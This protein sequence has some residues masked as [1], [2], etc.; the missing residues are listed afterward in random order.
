M[1]SRKTIFV[2]TLLFLTAGCIFAGLL[3]ARKELQTA[4]IET[5]ILVYG[6]SLGGTS[7]AIIAAEQE[8]N[9]VFA[10][11]TNIM[12]GQA[13]ES[14]LSAFD[15]QRRQWETWG[16]YDDLQQYL[17]KKMGKN[18]KSK[19]AGLGISVVG[20]V[21]SP[22]DEI[23]AFFQER[24][25]SNQRITLFT[26]HTISNFKKKKGQWYQATL[27]N[28]QNNR[29]TR[30]RFQYLVDGTETG[31][32]FEQ[33]GTPFNI[34]LDA[35][36]ETGEK[37]ALPKEV[38]DAIVNGTTLNGKTL[39][40]LGNRVQAVASPFILLD[41]GY[42][43]DF[44]PFSA[45]TNPCLSPDTT[46]K[47]M[48][49]DAKVYRMEQEHCTARIMLA[50]EFTDT[51]DVYLVSHG[52]GFVQSA[53]ASSL[54]PNNPLVRQLHVQKNKETIHVGAFP[55]SPE[56]QT[57]L[58]VSHSA[59]NPLV[60]G[61]LLVKKNM[62]TAPVVLQ[63][64]KA[65]TIPLVHYD[66]PSVYA[67][68]YLTGT[69]LPMDSAPSI[70]NKPTSLEA[71][72][73]TLYIPHI[74]LRDRPSLELPSGL[75]D[76]L[77]SIVIIPT[78][79]DVRPLQFFS[80]NP[81]KEIPVEKIP[82]ESTIKNTDQ[83]VREWQFTAQDDGMTVFA[84]DSPAYQWRLLELWQDEPKQ[85]V[86]SLIFSLQ[87]VS[88]NPSPLFTAKL[89]KGSTY[90]LRIG[91]S[92]GEKW[93]SFTISADAIN[94]SVSLYTDSPLKAI[95]PHQEQQEGIYDLWAEGALSSSVSCTLERP[96][97][98]NNTLQKTITHPQLE[99]LGKVF[100]DRS[101]TLKINENG[102]TVIAIPNTAV[103]T[104]QWSGTL[105]GESPKLT[106]TTLPPGIFNVT[107]TGGP[108]E[109][110]Q[111]YALLEG[112][113][114][115]VQT[116]SIP[117]VKTVI[118]HRLATE[119]FVSN[120]RPLTLT[121]APSFSQS[122]ITLHFYKKIPNLQDALTFSMISHPLTP[123]SDRSRISL[124]F[125][126]NIVS[127]ES[128]LAGKP[129]GLLPTH[130]ARKTLGM[131]V[132][133]DGPN[134]YAGF[135]AE[136]IDSSAV[137]AASRERSEAFAYWL[138][139]DSALTKQNLNCD[140]ADVVCTPKR[141]QPVIGLFQDHLSMFPPK[142]Y[143]REGR[144]MVAKRMITLNDVGI[145]IQ[146]C[147]PTGCPAH[148]L[149]LNAKNE[150]C[151]SEEQTPLIFP[152]ALASAGYMVDIHLLF[153]S[154]EF[155]AAVQPLVRAL[156]VSSDFFPLM[157][158]QW[159]YPFS[160]PTEVPLSALLPVENTHL[161]P[162]S[163]TIGMSQLANGAYRTH[164]N[165]MAIGQAVG[166]LL[167]YCIEHQLEP[168]TLTGASLRS[169]Q[170]TLV[171]RDVLLY[172]ISDS[173]NPS[174]SKAVQHLIVEELLS[175]QIKA[176]SGS[177]LNAAFPMA[178]YYVSPAADIDQHDSKVIKLFL[179][180]STGKMTYRDLIIAL[181]P[182][183]QK[184]ESIS[185]LHAFAVQDGIVDEKHLSLSPEILLGVTPSKEDLYRAAYLLM[186]PQWTKSSK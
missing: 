137:I 9:V 111:I 145:P 157:S 68:I 163:H 149:P 130:L 129:E 109:A 47:S 32:L 112:G 30:I 35:A 120:G 21:N 24:V 146:N 123:F 186:Q 42:P 70:D 79:F 141:T 81:D 151:I 96:G 10:M 100:L 125:F 52:S 126:R 4:I 162:A 106:L 175:P 73:T 170:H 33:T 19:F 82:V 62:R 138:L 23:A 50:P 169:L 124:F 26:E 80:G 93:N 94:H 99:Y 167:S 76:S 66:V 171:E 178:D 104:Y 14:G 136:D 22:V 5:D 113:S 11:D 181:H 103:D 43:G 143:I 140:P 1:L 182:N 31:R 13:V 98:Q 41:R 177:Y 127:R 87:N 69:N 139:Y 110:S 118:D 173:S 89:T 166:H 83:P 165:E 150:E 57:I 56:R 92:R 78:E 3:Y 55:L 90:K 160:K 119:T 131:A 156:K 153:S 134:N 86:K 114:T 34:G 53:I 16:L 38:R 8:A 17:K 64:P 36:E 164:V 72:Q 107:V 152:D 45:D 117:K 161:I 185:A 105:S 84:I 85:L 115:P 172:P 174:L 15:D 60:E 144:R 74:S 176:N 46:I 58:S 27:T 91:L 102:P 44:V 51:Y 184:H 155:Y 37:L 63:K 128:V 49:V 54:W 180:E 179:Q 148:C 28:K 108:A 183:E 116:L 158:D 59:G 132:V 40:G 25:R 142:P 61:V 18:S 65:L 48:I 20:L 154:K 12:G 147:E 67:D 121:F 75:R 29:S 97:M 39:T 159:R 168:S 77:S 2:E 6:S 88:R 101:T 133:I 135:Q 122:P 7:A 95:T 71:T